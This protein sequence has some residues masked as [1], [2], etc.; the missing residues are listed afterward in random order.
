MVPGS[1]LGLCG[2]NT[3]IISCTPSLSYIHANIPWKLKKCMAKFRVGDHKL[4]IET[5]RHYRPK[6]P[7]SLTRKNMYYINVT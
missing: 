6:I 4:K 1:P 7:W 5:G 3:S 2:N